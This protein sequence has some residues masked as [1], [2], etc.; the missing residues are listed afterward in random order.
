VRG[1]SY[2]FDSKKGRMKSI[3][4]NNNNGADY[5]GKKCTSDAIGEAPRRSWPEEPDPTKFWIYQVYERWTY[6]YMS[7]LLKKG[8]KQTLDDGTHLSSE[9]LHGIPESMQS[10]N[11]SQRFWYVGWGEAPC[12]WHFRASNTC[13][14]TMWCVCIG[15]RLY[16]AQAGSKKQLVTTLLRV[17]AP[18]FIP[19]GFCQLVT[20]FMNVA[21]PLLVMQLLTLLEQ[22]PG[23]P[24]AQKGLPYS[25]AIFLT[26]VVHGF[27]FHRHRHLA[28]KTGVLLRATVVNVVYEQVL[29]LTPKGRSGLT[30]GQVANLVAVD[31]QK[32]RAKCAGNPK[33]NYYT[34]TFVP[35]RHSCTKSLKKRT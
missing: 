4:M 28:M 13:V 27:A 20:V 17:V 22:N 11:L 9:D 5:N 23:M 18:T 19:A 15:R 26:V 32:V 3:T 21:M 6:S 31:T 10:S 16:E 33:L 24:L 12:L 35:L 14:L 30:S 7:P 34:H 29:R 25:V 8:A 1:A 2:Y